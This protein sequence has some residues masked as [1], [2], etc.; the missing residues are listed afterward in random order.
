M[1]FFRISK[2]FILFIFISFSYSCDQAN[3]K[4]ITQIA[5]A[6]VDKNFTAL[7]TYIKTPDPAFKYELVNTIKEKNYSV[8]LVKMVSQTWLTTAEV[9]DPVWWH[10]LT[11][12]VPD[13]VHS[14]IAL[15]T[16]GGGSRTSKQPTSADEVAVKAAMTTHSVVASLHN[17]PN[18]KI[19]FVG[20]DFG[21]RVED[22]LISYGWRKYLEGGA[23]DT[24]AKWLARLPMTKSAVR[25]MDVISM[26]TKKILPKKVEQF[27]VAGGSKRGW[28]TWTTGAV[29]DRVIGIAPIV[30][31]MLN[32]VPSFLHHWRVYGRWAEAVGDYDREGIMD[33]QNRPEYKKLLS[34]TEPY[35]Y[36]SRLDMPK[37]IINASGDQFFLPDSW[38]FYW[39]DLI[40]EKHIRYVPNGEHSLK[41]TDAAETLV[42]FYN[43]IVTN[44]PRP[45]FDWSVE[46]GTILIR[47][48][49]KETPSSIKLWQAHN[50]KER[51]FRVD[52]IDRTWKAKEIPLRADGIYHLKIDQPKTGFSAFFAELSFTKDRAI[53]FK[54]STGVVIT[55]DIYLYDSFVPK[56]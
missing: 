17:V 29:D 27:V 33:W 9:K 34:I 15:L 47:T 5:P 53:P 36:R 51:D 22:E 8:Y 45:Q 3:T 19:E 32:M 2:I 38:K 49:A 31:D 37:M 12:V 23:K 7:D 54:M 21:P 41:G 20:D 6:K 40:G 56:R 10:W 11:I 42:A 18:Q 35:S 26:M 13:E 55:P 44:H 16:I 43:D 25:A 50:P 48:N 1:S 39:K 30:I 4:A 14:Q 46:N 28:T 52:T 24:D